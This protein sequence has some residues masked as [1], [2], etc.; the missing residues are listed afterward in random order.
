MHFKFCILSFINGF[1][2]SL[3]I[4]KR[5][6]TLRIASFISLLFVV[7]LLSSSLRLNVLITRKVP[8]VQMEPYEIMNR[9]RESNDLTKYKKILFWNEAYG[10]KTYDIGIGSDVFLRAG[11]PVWKCTTTDNRTTFK[12]EELDAVVFHQRS[13]YLV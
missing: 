3:I 13:W 5:Q 9:Y 2:N 10:G 7:I 12:P 4:L 1:T 6:F 11:C 8:S